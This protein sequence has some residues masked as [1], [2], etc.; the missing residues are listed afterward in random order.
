MF[1][2]EDNLEVFTDIGAVGLIVKAMKNHLKVFVL[3][4]NFVR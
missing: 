3:S 4:N 2:L 1:F